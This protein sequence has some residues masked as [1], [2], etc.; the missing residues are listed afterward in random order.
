MN[1]TVFGKT[2]E[3]VKKHRDAKLVTTEIRRNYLLSE[4]NYHAANFF[5]EKFISNRNKKQQLNYTWTNL[6]IWEGQY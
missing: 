2:K 1:N 4:R 3:N 6:F 5:S